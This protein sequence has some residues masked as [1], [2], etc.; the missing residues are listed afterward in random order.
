M[1]K[2]KKYQRAAV[3]LAAL[4]VFLFFPMKQPL[5]SS[6]YSRVITDRN[7][8]IMRVFLNSNQQY[9]LPPGFSDT[10][11]EKLK[12]AVIHFED[13]Y[14]RYH[15]GIN[16]VSLVRAIIQNH[17]EKRT[18]SGAS[19]ITM[20][21][22]RIRKGRRRTP[23]NKTLEMCEALRI[24]ARFSKDEILKLYLDHAPYG[25]NIIGYQAA[26]WRYFGKP[27]VQLSW[28]E[29]CL[30]AVLPNSPGKMSP[31]KNNDL[32]REKRNRLLKSLY[33]SH[34]IDTA[35]LNNSLNEH[36]PAEIVPF[37]L[38]APHLAQRMDNET[39][40]KQ[41]IVKTSIDASIQQRANYLVQRYSRLLAYYGIQNTAV[42]VIENKNRKVR[43]YIGSQDFYGTAGMN[44][45][46]KAMRSSGS[47]L[48]PFLYALAFNDGLILPG[49]LMQDIPT[50]YGS[51]SP[52]NASEMYS[53][54]VTAQDA[55]VR[56]LNVP[57]VRLLY[58]Y[59]HYRFYQF[60]KD[61]G[62]STLFRPADSYGLPLIIGGAEVTLEEISAMY[63]GLAN[64]GSFAPLLYV[65]DEKPEQQAKN[66]IDTLSSVMVLNV[67]NN[68]QRPGA[69]YYWTK[70][71][72]QFPVAW[73]TG[74]SYGH[75]DA[76]AVGA[77]PLYTVG[78]W[79][80]NF[81]AA[82][83]KNLS[84]AASAGPLLFDIFDIL[85]HDADNAWW[86]FNDYNFETIKVCA[87]TGY[88]ASGR[89]DK[90]IETRAPQADKLRQCMYCI[91]TEVDS[92][93]EFRVCSRCW[94]NGHHQ[95]K[96]LSYP[97]LVME[98]LR[99]NGEVTE[100][101]PP[102][103]PECTATRDNN[104]IE[105]AYPEEGAKIMVSRDF[106]GQYQPVVFSAA[107]QI[108]NQNIFWYID[109]IYLGMTHKNHK[110]ACIPEKGNH[111]LTLVDSY[112]NTKN[113]SFYATR[114]Q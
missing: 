83:N 26:A 90:I 6:N 27:P 18:V 38:V 48:K 4:L 47:L 81:D 53:G 24:E 104:L 33:M 99:K 64:L 82:T 36:M 40:Q 10:L 45:G 86:N 59:G 85:P 100:R 32:L 2:N 111:S 12:L 49:S 75:K 109:N 1:I 7:G 65:E 39:S 19:T 108:A 78:V 102:H 44:D 106:N 67:L 66:L 94:Q 28:A 41:R 20:Q 60:L 35:T 93:N 61:A 96:Y 34:T 95:Q 113:T 43:A 29:A 72:N 14:F 62:I 79:V 51:F 42:I 13:R 87:S 68:L 55:L 16:P 74:T 84:G 63:C 105:I 89:C 11:P 15:P 97:P 3:I 70:F 73:K 112:G 56:S 80:G 22:A 57:A 98:Y 52:S 37:D 25:G 101:I 30:L 71:N 114:S 46:V 9:C 50:F 31:V 110:M 91:K 8:Q 5:V 103:N 23:I 17:K 76:W 69:E 92:L 77:N 58:T 21:L 107:H 54:M 88:M